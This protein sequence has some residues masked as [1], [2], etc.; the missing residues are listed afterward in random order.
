MNTQRKRK[1]EMDRKTE[2]DIERERERGSNNFKDRFST[3]VFSPRR[4]PP[5]HRLRDSMCFEFHNVIYGAWRNSFRF[6]GLR[7]GK[8][9]GQ[10]RFNFEVLFRRVV[11]AR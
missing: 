6:L 10:Q 8:I 7:E 2:R 3:S 9:Y 4:C 1:K 11:L 5:Y